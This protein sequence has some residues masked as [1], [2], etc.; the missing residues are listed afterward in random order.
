MRR[1]CGAFFSGNLL[2][3]LNFQQFREQF[4][5][6]KLPA[7]LLLV[8]CAFLIENKQVYLTTVTTS[9][10]DASMCTLGFEVDNTDE[11]QPDPSVPVTEVLTV[12]ACA[13][14]LVS[15]RPSHFTTPSSCRYKLP[16][17]RAPPYA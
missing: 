10:V 12:S 5:R 8:F 4:I 15:V 13:P 11:E 16:P 2:N 9:H 6:Q 14:A 1:I 7:L 3:M 17:P